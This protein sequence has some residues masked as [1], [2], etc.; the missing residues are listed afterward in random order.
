VKEHSVS[1]IRKSDPSKYRFVD[2]TS[3]VLDKNEKNKR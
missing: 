1:I 3:I 2:L